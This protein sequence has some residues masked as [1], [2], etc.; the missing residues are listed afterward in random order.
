MST[1]SRLLCAVG[2]AAVILLLLLRCEVVKDAGVLEEPADSLVIETEEDQ[3]NDQP[4]RGICLCWIQQ[5]NVLE[6]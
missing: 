4:R 6:I 5:W 1:R 2:A 3:T